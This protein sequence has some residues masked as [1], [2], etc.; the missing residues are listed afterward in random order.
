M[1]RPLLVVA[2]LVGSSSAAASDVLA[3]GT[4]AAVGGFIGG[5]VLA[6]A[7]MSAELYQDDPV[8]VAGLLSLAFGA[9]VVG[10]AIGAG[11]VARS[12]AVD[13]RLAIPAVVVAAIL[14]PIG[15]MLG[16]IV[17]FPLA[18]AIFGE[19]STAPPFNGTDYAVFTTTVVFTGLGS[20]LA[21]AGGSALGY[22][23]GRLFATDEE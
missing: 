6:T 12:R 22:G 10:P 21:A 8:A 17:G 2:L 7:G 16:A 14:S 5:A 9:A 18:S 19:T 11:V 1:L 20:A 3:L 23:G 13:A 4:G 15:G